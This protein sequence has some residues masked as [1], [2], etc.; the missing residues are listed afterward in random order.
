MKVSNTLK[1][2][3]QMCDK[4]EEDLA[5][6]LVNVTHEESDAKNDQRHIFLIIFML[7]EEC[8]HYWKCKISIFM[9]STVC[10]M[11]TVEH[12]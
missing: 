10:G 2:L 9:N 5:G 7:M 8:K 6:I 3:A 11:L 1:V 12:F 4:R